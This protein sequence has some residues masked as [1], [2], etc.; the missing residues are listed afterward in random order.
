M[1]LR[2]VVVQMGHVLKINKNILRASLT[3]PC[4]PEQLVQRLHFARRYID[5]LMRPLL[6]H[7]HASSSHR[8]VVAAHDVDEWLDAGRIVWL[9]P[10]MIERL[11]DRDRCC[12]PRC[13]RGAMSP[14]RSGGQHQVSGHRSQTEGC[15]QA[16]DSVWRCAHCTASLLYPSSA[17]ACKPFPPSPARTVTPR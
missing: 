3:A 8:A 6:S 4:S 15:L 12:R 17:I 9:R 13:V 16:A 5:A 2:V 10:G 11:L 1:G 14:L 7:A